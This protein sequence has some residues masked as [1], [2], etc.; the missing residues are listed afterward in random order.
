LYDLAFEAERK[1]SSKRGAGHW[2]TER[3]TNGLSRP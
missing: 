1:W 2:Q 3:I